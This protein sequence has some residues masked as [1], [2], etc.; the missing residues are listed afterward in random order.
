MIGH[1]KT[2]NVW[3]EDKPLFE[4]RGITKAF[5][6]VLANDHIDLNI[7][8]GE[9]HALLGEN[10]AGKST[11]SK[12]LYGFY[13]LD[14]GEIRF[15]NK[16]VHFHS[17]QDA[18]KFHIGMVFQNFTLIPAM[19][20]VENIALFLPDLGLVLDRKQI[21]KKIDSI[22][23]RFHLEV[24][25]LA[26]VW[27]LSIGEQQKVE[28]LK[29]LLANVRLLIL[30]EP[31]KVL[32]PHEIAGLFKVMRGLK[33][34]GYAVI[35]ITHKIREVLECADR[36][37]VM[38]HGRVTGQL[39]RAEA[40]E[41]KIIEMMF[42][43][44]KIKQ[45]ERVVKAGASS[46]KPL[47]EIKKVS[48]K[49]QGFSV[50]LKDINLKISQ[51]EIVGVA[52]VSG[53]GQKELGDLILGLLKCEEGH[54]FLFGKNATHWHIGKVRREGTAFIPE[55][56]LSMAAVPNMTSQENMA[57]NN[58]RKYS[59][60]HGFFIDLDT[61]LNDLEQSFENLGLTAPPFLCP[62]K[63]LSG[64]NIQRVIIAREFAQSAELIVAFYPT[65]GLDVLSTTAV[66]QVLMRFRD[67][68]CGIILISD[69]LE[70]LF[71]MS[72]RLIV[73]YQGKMVGHYK[74]E[75]TNMVNIGHLMTGARG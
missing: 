27:Q 75:E 19:T 67:S 72:D 8:K 23:K 28:V 43:K 4:L 60:R 45:V 16:T 69:D 55:N 62:I 54:K 15:Q 47:L 18:R 73:L 48:T 37:T 64:G 33:E 10:G 14:S 30:D 9:I 65:K 39:M 53:N 74:P 17:P 36:I 31:T 3:K 32:A 21:I 70:E 66:R 1:S 6:N 49:A 41:D 22:S 20:V 7:W 44:T 58:T 25:P 61:A 2:S 56:P 13:K 35:F 38:R 34:E 50:G 42:G 40:S 29:L 71:S 51:G 59:R 52:G 11:L 12:I 57:V 24:E 68:G 46:S 26:P 63:T 5:P